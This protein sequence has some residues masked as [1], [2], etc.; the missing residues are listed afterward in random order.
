MDK[1]LLSSG[2][3]YTDQNYMSMDHS[4][5]DNE[6]G[7]WPMW[8]EL[9]AKELKLK[10]VNVGE[11]G[12]DNSYILDSIIDGISTYG[13]SIDT[14]A[15]LW[16]SADRMPFFNNSLIPLAELHIMLMDYRTTSIDEWM[17][18]FGLSDLSYTVMN[19]KNF[20]MNKM[21][22]TWI[23]SPL[24]KLFTIIELCDKF[25]YK[26]VMGQGPS[27]FQEKPINDLVTE[28]YF[29]TKYQINTK[30]KISYFMS[31]PQFNLLEQSR[32]K[33]I[34]WPFMT[35]IG[36]WDFDI[37]R[38]QQHNSD[39]ILTVSNLDFHPNAKGQEL[40]A[41]IFIDRWNKLYR[42]TK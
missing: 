27:Y 12:R 2:C 26:L 33:I 29:N 15:I 19:N 17:K 3:S 18:R 28:G 11:K 1:I 37:I 40:F 14:I 4:I 5:P 20:D 30:D 21:L 38:A 24:K 23:Q 42:N 13:E 9:M 22:Q 8:P 34:G 7:G 25:N 41:K 39:N 32:S 16:S 10:S 36:G 6:R 35:E 31:S